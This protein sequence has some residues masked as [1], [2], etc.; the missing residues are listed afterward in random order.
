MRTA[1]T[2][3]CLAGLLLVL[4][5]H[6]HAASAQPKTDEAE[7][8][9]VEQ[10]L[11]VLAT[12]G[13]REN[14]RLKQTVAAIEELTRIGA[15]AAPQLVEALLD[16]PA[17]S[18]VSFTSGRIL[19]DIGKPALPTVTARWADLNDGQRWRLMPFREKYDLAA[20]R[21]YAWNCLA[22]DDEAIR[23]KA[24]AFMIRQREPRAK[25]RYLNA[26]RGMDRD[27][28]GEDARLRWQLLSEKPVY[29]EKQETDIL[30]DL[31]KPD[32]WAAKGE[33]YPPR[34]GFQPPWFPDER[35]A[36]VELLRRRKLDRAAPVLLK[37]LQ[38][39]GPGAGYLVESIAPALVDFKYAEAIPELERI[40]ASKP[41]YED[42][43]KVK[44]HPYAIGGHEAVKK[45]AAEAAKKL[46]AERK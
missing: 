13:A 25:D 33:G 37:V 16:E 12:P 20:V 4:P 31:L 45:L 39:K 5:T 38:E 18:N 27:R 34:D 46:S 7:R 30:I 9:R 23:G 32:G 43:E 26:L 17:S 29:D 8:K 21:E 40:A 6:D 42:P 15:P 35:P 2:A 1:V 28:G 3:C 10:L 36:V 11:A 14:D 44:L 41:L 19:L 24:W 22:S